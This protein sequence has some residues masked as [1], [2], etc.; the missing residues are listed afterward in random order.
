MARISGLTVPF[1]LPDSLDG[2][3]VRQL[4]GMKL[5]LA[6]D[7]FEAYDQA[8]ME[9]VRTSLN[10]SCGFIIMP[11]EKCNFRC[12]YCYESFERGR[13]SKANVE[14]MSLAIRKKAST[15]GSFSLGFFGG[16]P[17]LC[18]DL[19]IRFSQEAFQVM[20]SRGRPYA[21]GIATNG[22]FLDTELFEQLLDAGVCSFQITIDGDR[23]VHDQQRLTIRGEKT[24]DT[25]VRNVLAMREIDGPFSCIVRCNVQRSDYPRVLDL[26]DGGEFSALREDPRF[27]IDVHEIWASDRQQI[28]NDETSAACGSSLGNQLDFFQLTGQLQSLGFETTAHGALPSVLGQSCYAG[29]PNWFVVGPKLDVYKCTVVFDNPLNQVGKIDEQ[30]NLVLDEEKNSLW[31]DSNA[32]TDAGCQ[33]C[34]LRVPC[35]G[36]A[37]PLSRFTNGSKACLDLKTQTNLVRWANRNQP[38]PPRQETQ[39][40]SPTLYQLV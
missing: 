40:E 6:E 34:H 4:T 18:P 10:G 39:T 28:Q 9:L 31:T 27:H 5:I 12:T 21:A 32:L 29:K 8:V 23:Q 33:A 3:A 16:E 36:I 13:M 11:T 2:D 35:G 14:A 25:I 37:C 22:Y 7:E 19:V 30:G 15:A 1:R 24:F 17:L 38:P 20:A 26:F